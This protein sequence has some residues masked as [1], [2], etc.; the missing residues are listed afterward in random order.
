[1]NVLH[2]YKTYYPD[3]FGGVEKFID[4]L[5]VNSLTYG[6]TSQ[7]LTLTKKKIASKIEI[8]GY[9]VHKIPQNFEIASCPV[10]FRAISQFMKL[11][12]TTDIIHYHFPW[13][14]MDI[15]HFI[16]KVG[17]PCILTYHSDIVKQKFL[18]KLYNPIMF[19]F[20]NSVNHIIAT[21]PNYVKSSPILTKFINKTSIIPIGLN[22]EHYP[23]PSQ[24][25]IN[26]W[27]NKLGNNFFLF[28]GAIRYYKGL[29]FLIEAAD[30]TT[31]I[32]IIGSGN[33][34][35]IKLK[36]KV[37]NL[38]IQNIYFLGKLEEEDKIA[39]LTLCYALVFPSHLRSEAFGI[40]LLEGAMFGK[41]LISCEIGTG[42][43]YINIANETGIVVP[44][45][46]PL[47][48]KQAMKFLLHNPIQAQKMGKLAEKRYK[49]LFTAED[50]TKS[51]MK[52]YNSYQ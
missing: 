19:S 52:I 30:V 46:D 25:K 37:Q 41:P 23:I 18:L 5:I 36:S 20:L 51:Y 1:M 17:K 48:L 35:E 33:N 4:Q 39:V 10:S 32:V 14:F 44:P 27:Y 31:P 38:N 8:N 34:L 3:T 49:E 42:T 45:S 26:F 29:E 6:V 13:P 16:A 15:M 47:A 21:S 7:V 43:T 12:K 11:I 22:K 9:T 28:I 50:M 40:S 24:K 2:I